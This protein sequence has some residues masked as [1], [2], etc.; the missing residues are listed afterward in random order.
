VFAADWKAKAE[1]PQIDPILKIIKGLRQYQHVNATF[2][3][4]FNEVE[5][6]VW[7]HPIP[8]NYSTGGHA[9]VIR[10]YYYV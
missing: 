2:P 3:Q 1:V 4:N 9:L 5:T 10:N 7:K 6:R 8:P